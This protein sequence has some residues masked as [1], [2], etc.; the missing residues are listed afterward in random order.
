MT[1]LDEEV[2]QWMKSLGFQDN[3]GA[4]VPNYSYS[5][6]NQYIDPNDIIRKVAEDSPDWDPMDD[7]ILISP[8]LAKIFYLASGGE[9]KFKSGDKVW[10][11]RS[12]LWRKGKIMRALGNG[13]YLVKI[14]IYGIYDDVESEKIYPRGRKK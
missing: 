5:M 10:V 1:K 13:R 14:G 6:L 11:G 7:P 8:Q 2:R 3:T 9:K 12:R 4:Q